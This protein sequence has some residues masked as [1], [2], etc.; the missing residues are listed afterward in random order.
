MSHIH[1]FNNFFQTHAFR[2]GISFG[3]VSSAMTVLGISLGV[4]SSGENL[5]AIIS[6]VVGLSISNSLA[7]A[8]S[9]Y[10]SDTASGQSKDA[11][12]SAIITAIIEGILP[13]IFLIPFLTMKLRNA[14]IVNVVMGIFLVAITGI[15]VSKLHNNS[16]EKMAENVSIYIS[17]TVIIMILTYASGLIINKLLKKRIN[18]M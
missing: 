1:H 5:R 4:W 8:F 9:M 16:D 15:Y 11:L 2:Q 13:F 18:G 12:T 14:I 17:I 6:S 10:M 3:I 7:D